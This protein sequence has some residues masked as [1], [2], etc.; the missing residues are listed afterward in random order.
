MNKVLLKRSMFYACTRYI[1]LN[2]NLYI[3]LIFIVTFFFKYNA[4]L[5]NI[6]H[7]DYVYIYIY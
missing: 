3:T 6:S 1:I 7:K 2:H 4:L 5:E